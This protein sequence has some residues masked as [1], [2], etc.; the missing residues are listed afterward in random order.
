MV[1]I[2]PRR[3]P[4]PAPDGG[5]DQEAGPDEAPDDLWF[6]DDLDDSERK[7]AV[8]PC[9]YCRR[10][11]RDDVLDRSVRRCGHAAAGGPP[12]GGVSHDGC[13]DLHVARCPRCAIDRQ[14]LCARHAAELGFICESCRQSHGGACGTEIGRLAFC[15]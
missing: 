5:L 15:G 4:E 12:C 14:T 8:D 1:F 10:P 3:R 6:L 7:P 2:P 13:L 9:G 11:V